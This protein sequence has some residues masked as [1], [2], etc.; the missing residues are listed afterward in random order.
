MKN[1]KRSTRIPIIIL[2]NE[3]LIVFFREHHHVLQSQRIDF[4]YRRPRL[5]DFVFKCAHGLIVH[6]LPTDRLVGLYADL[7]HSQDY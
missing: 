1:S 6:L 5:D 7:F 4:A 3:N 2:T